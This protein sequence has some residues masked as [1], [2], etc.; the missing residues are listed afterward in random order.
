MSD[1]EPGSE[2][3]QWAEAHRWFA[4]AEEDIRTAEVCLEVTPQLVNAAAFHCQQAAEKLIKGLLIAGARKA[5]KSHDL[6]RLARLVAEVF[7][8]L[9]G[10]LLSIRQLTPWY[11]ATRYP[12]IDVG[13]QP[14]A[15]EVRDVLQ[16]LGALRG[17]VNALDP[18]SGKRSQG[19]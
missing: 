12:D 15:S 16:R 13:P 7:P 17:K 11:V 1:P 5:E 4:Y 14:T 6:D 19:G 8:E 2:A 9:G 18:N 3:V 10:D